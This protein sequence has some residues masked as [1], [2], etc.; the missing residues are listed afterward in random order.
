MQQNQPD[1]VEEISLL[2]F[3]TPIQQSDASQALSVLL[4]SFCHVLYSAGISFANNQHL[5]MDCSRLCTSHAYARNN[6]APL[7]SSYI[8]EEQ[9]RGVLEVF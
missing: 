8:L 5:T 3:H 7:L 2:M 6:L 9:Y 1:P 4:H